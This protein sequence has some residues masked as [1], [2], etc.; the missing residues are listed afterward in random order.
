MI[1]SISHLKCPSPS[2]FQLNELLEEKV[3]P[4]I[5]SIDNGA[6]PQ[7]IIIKSEEQDKQVFLSLYCL[8][9]HVVT[10]YLP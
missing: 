3:R 9:L 10:C 1:I 7:P 6:L 5:K 8:I 2:V 4:H